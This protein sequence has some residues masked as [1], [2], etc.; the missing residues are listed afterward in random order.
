MFLVNSR[1]GLLTAAPS[2][3]TQQVA[4]RYAGRPF[5]RSY[6]AN[7]PSSLTEVL[8][9]TLVY[10]TSPPVSVCGTVT[11]VLARGFS[12]QYRLNPCGLALA[13]RAFPS[14]LGQRRR[15]ICLSALPT[16][17]DGSATPGPSPPASP[18]RSNGRAR[19]RNINL[20]SIAYALAASA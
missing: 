7:L 4:S 19:D 13:A 5:S 9:S 16:G 8:S 14:P 6:G 15:R 10:S 3:S 17:L 2:R 1:L 20:L 18:H 11:H 12:W